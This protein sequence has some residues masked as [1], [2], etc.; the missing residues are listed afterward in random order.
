MWHSYKIRRKIVNFAL[1]LLSHNYVFYW[2]ASPYFENLDALNYYRTWIM[3]K[4]SFDTRMLLLLPLFSALLTYHGMS[5]KGISTIRIISSGFDDKCSNPPFFTSNN[6]QLPYFPN[7]EDVICTAAAPKNEPFEYLKGKNTKRW[8]ATVHGLSSPTRAKCTFLWRFN[9]FH[10]CFGCLWN[11]VGRLSLLKHI[12][13]IFHA[14]Y[15]RVVLNHTSIG[16][17]YKETGLFP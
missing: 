2:L 13:T 1:R 8:T 6:L 12:D 4:P 5:V 9:C 17:I 10:H 15:C 7:N 11:Y 3:S 14:P 16:F